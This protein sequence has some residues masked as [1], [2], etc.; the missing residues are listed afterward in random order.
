MANEVVKALLVEIDG[1]VEK[2]RKALREGG[3]D[4][5]KFGKQAV[6][7]NAEAGASADQ[8]GSKSAMAARGAASAIETIT[9]SGKV[10]GE[11][12]KQLIAQGSGVVGMFGAT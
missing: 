4:L 2:L 8:F 5:E 11:S 1:N 7:T 10:G 9:R 6:R 3:V 12:M